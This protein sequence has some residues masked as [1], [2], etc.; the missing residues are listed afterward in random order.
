MRL[1]QL[2]PLLVLTALPA[3]SLAQTN[4]YYN[5]QFGFSV[6]IP[7]GLY[8]FSPHQMTGMDH[9]RQFFFKPTSVEDCNNGGCDRYIAVDAYYNS[10]EDTAKLHDFLKNECTVFGGPKCLQAPKDLTNKKMA[11][12][13]ARADLPNGRVEIL[14]VTQAGK[15]NPNVD[16]AA[17]SINYSIYLLTTKEHLEQD[18]LPFRVILRTIRISPTE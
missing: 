9:G 13:S 3:Q 16:D 2:V 17:P 8:L 4:V 15:P 10:I 1:M 7:Q 11:S 12:E 5:R 18:L 14:V 6:P